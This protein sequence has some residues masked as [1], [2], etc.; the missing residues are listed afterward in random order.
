[1]KL[2]PPSPARTV[3][4]GRKEDGESKEEV[5]VGFLPDYLGSIH[6]PL[7]KPDSNSGFKLIRV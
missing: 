7:V 6:F 3:N 4:R 1:M 5:K 2:D